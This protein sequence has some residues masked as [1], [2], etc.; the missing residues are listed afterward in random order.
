MEPN[1]DEA[2]RAKANAEKKFAEKDFLG[3]RDYAVKA[4]KLCPELE[5]ISQMVATYGVYLASE[6]KINGEFDFYSILGLDSSVDKSKLK[7]QYKKMAVLLHPDKNKTV[8]ADGAFRL[9]S[10]AW[11]LLSDSVK[12]SSYDHRRNLSAGNNVGAGVYD[13]YSKF[14]AS[15][16]RLDTF[17]TVCTSC[18]VQYEYLRKYVNKR[19]SCK[20]CRGVF[21]AIETGLAPVDGSFSYGPWSYVSESGYGNHAT[22]IPMTTGYC[23]PNGVSG[24]HTGHRSECSNISFQCNSSS[25][26]SV[27]ILDPNG[28]STSSVVFYQANGKANKTKSHGKHHVV[29]ATVHMVSNACTGSNGIS[30]SKRGRPTKKRKV[31]FG[32]I[33]VSGH[34]EVPPKSAAEVKIANGNGN[35][36]PNSK[37]PLPFET[38]IKRSALAPAFDA[39]QLLIDKARSEIRRKL[40]EIRLASEAEAAEVEK[41]KTHAKVDKSCEAAIISGSIGTG[42]RAELKRTVSMSI[43][44]PD[45]DFHD[46]DKDR[47]EECFKPKQIWAL[48]DEDGMPRLYCLIRE[49]ISVRPFKIFIS[50]L[51]SKSDSE[52]GSVNWLVSGF[53]KSCGNFRAFNSEII[54]QVNIFSHLLSREKAGRGGCVRIYPRSGDIWA[55]YRNWSLDWNRKT[56]NEVR[57]QYEMVEVLDN[58]SEDHGVWVAPLVKL[59]GFKTVYQ[60]NTSND[61]VRLIQRKEMLRFSHQVPS[62]LLKIEG[63]N[64]PEG[65]WDLDPAATPEEL[66][67][68]ETEV[69]NDVGPGQ[70]EKFIDV[71]DEKCPAEF[72]GRADEKLSQMK[73]FTS[74]PD[75]LHGVV[76]DTFMEE[77]TPAEHPQTEMGAKA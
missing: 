73:N 26:K 69:C 59:D 54:E 71:I 76:G 20:N 49:V 40:E 77:R 75:K 48:Y 55:V 74:S 65:C 8:G 47:S 39:R 7:K 45:S 57:H 10:E 46:F 61:A 63:T 29:E 44:V 4:Q 15:H 53:T 36:D 67:R 17:W 22:Y 43:T 9:V 11:T 52:F 50:Y 41:R 51:S 27:G 16:R 37:L 30:V 19:L 72:E 3:A 34:E 42:H 58:Y 70:T 13:N 6:K 64:L 68:V 5:G 1:I 60:R 62:C 31:D 25:G 18:H 66:L 24:H 21:I 2:L 35:L 32:N 56:P 23:A 14:S 38:S 33:L 12:R 28:L